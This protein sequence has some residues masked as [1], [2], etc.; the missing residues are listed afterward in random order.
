MN[1]IESLYG[2][3]LGTVEKD[4]TQAMSFAAAHI[5]AEDDDE[6]PAYTENDVK[7]ITAKL[8]RTHVISILKSQLVRDNWIK[9]FTPPELGISPDQD[10]DI[11]NEATHVYLKRMSDLSRIHMDRTILGSKATVVWDDYGARMIVLTGGLWQPNR[12]R[13][14]QDHIDHDVADAPPELVL[15]DT[16]RQSWAAM[17][18]HGTVVLEDANGA[19]FNFDFDWRHDIFLLSFPSESL[20]SSSSGPKSQYKR[21]A[22]PSQVLAHLQNQKKAKLAALPEDKRK[23]AEERKRWAKSEERASGGKDADREKA[24][25][26]AVK[27]KE[28]G[29]A[30]SGKEWSERKRE[31][32]KSSEIAIK[33]RNDNLS[34]R[35]EDKRN[36]RA[37]GSADKKKGGSGGK[38]GGSGG[39][40]GGEWWW[41]R[42]GEGGETWV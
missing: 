35:L 17:N 7:Q 41:R 19:L 31:L 21:I 13:H 11:A 34:K 40:K 18:N 37:D 8:A 14:D 32:Q 33:K 39:G 5:A 38:K 16:A 42:E 36:K 3:V 1:T 27:R 6:V 15:E 24:L 23:E 29:K 9:A 4:L 22:N 20:P 25:K 30:K 10:A 2:D 26:N 12:S 28:K